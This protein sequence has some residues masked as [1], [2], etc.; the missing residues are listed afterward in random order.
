MTPDET[1]TTDPTPEAT[2]EQ[3]AMSEEPL[4]DAELDIFRHA[5]PESIFWF[6]RRALAEIERLRA[7][8]AERD[9][10][11]RDLLPMAEAWYD[12]NCEN[13]G[14]DPINGD[15]AT[16]QLRHDEQAIRRA[17]ALVGEA[18]PDER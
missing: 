2:P 13:G 16:E 14:Y 11:I 4:T 5:R 6:Q 15:W 12:H 10:A 17:K 18:V 7:V 9:A 8:V 3:A 1:M